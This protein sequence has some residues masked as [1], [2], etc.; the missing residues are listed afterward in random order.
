MKTSAALLKGKT[1]GLQRMVSAWTCIAAI[2]LGTLSDKSPQDTRQL[3]RKTADAF[4]SRGIACLSTLIPPNPP[5][6]LADSIKWGLVPDA[7]LRVRRNPVDEES[8]QLRANAGGYE[9]G[10][11]SSQQTIAMRVSLRPANLGPARCMV[12]GERMLPPCVFAR[13]PGLLDQPY[14]TPNARLS[15]TVV[16]R[17]H[18]RTRAVDFSSVSV[19][20]NRVEPDAAET[21]PEKALTGRAIDAKRATAV[22]AQREGRSIERTRPAAAFGAVMS[23]LGWVS[24]GRGDSV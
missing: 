5:R 23:V 7:R 6:L 11:G 12:A 13:A 4:A 16:W 17:G 1:W 8:M 9:S 2:G 24:F 22:A 10:F 19:V 15:L 3:R 21:A 14:C 20:A 18:P